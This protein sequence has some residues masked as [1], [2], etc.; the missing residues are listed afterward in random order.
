MT[1]AEVV[2]R[3]LDAYN[4]ADAE[5]FAATYAVDAV[6]HDGTGAVRRRGR[7]RI[8]AD[9]GRLFADN[10][11]LRAEVSERICLGRWVVDLEQVTGISGRQGVPALAVYRVE[12]DLIH[13]VR[14]LDP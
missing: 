4:A 8:A 5:A 14:L 13:E 9:Y 10:P 2:Q 6:V 1:P 7:D 11:E 3:Q 12:D